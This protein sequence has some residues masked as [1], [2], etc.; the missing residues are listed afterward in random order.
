MSPDQIISLAQKKMKQSAST[1]DWNSYYAIVID[2]IFTRKQWKFAQ[3]SSG[4]IQLASASRK[5]FSGYSTSLTTVTNGTTLLTSVGLFVPP[6]IVG[7]VI[8]G[9]GI[10]LGTT[11]VT[12]NTPSSITMSIAAT[13]STSN[14]R[15]FTGDPTLELSVNKLKALAYS[16]NFT[17]SGTALSPFVIDKGSVR[18]IMYV[19]LQRYREGIPDGGISVTTGNPMYYTEIRANDGTSGLDISI[20]PAPSSNVCVLWTADCIPSYAVNSSPM[21]ILPLQFHRLVYY[22]IVREAAE[23]IGQDRLATKAAN[24]FDQGIA[25]L[26][27]WD[28]KNPKYNVQ[29]LPYDDEF[30]GGYGYAGPGPIFPSNFPIR[31]GR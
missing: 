2:D 24:M 19:P 31:F 26:D 4:Y 20:W 13:D 28:S 14:S 7:Q 27:I 5:V 9:P 29:R 3:V 21:P 17:G 18:P 15:T 30:M 10:V 6:I 11:I 1:I 12:I 25:R 16:M 22:G 23:E 8:S